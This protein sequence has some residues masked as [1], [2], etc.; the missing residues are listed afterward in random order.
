VGEVAVPERI[1]G[2]RVRV[3]EVQG[4]VDR[5]VGLRFYRVFFLL[6]TYCVLF[7]LWTYCLCCVDPDVH[8]D[9]GEECLGV[10]ALGGAEQLFG[11]RDV[12]R[13][14]QGTNPVEEIWLVQSR[15][16]LAR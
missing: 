16:L 14:D 12:A 7:M 15:N 8:V 6:F 5:G 1:R 4:A 10:R 13:V 3:Q 2:Q 11:A 9:V